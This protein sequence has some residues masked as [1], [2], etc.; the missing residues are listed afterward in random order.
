MSEPLHRQRNLPHVWLAGL[1]KDRRYQPPPRDFS[2][3]RLPSRP[4]DVAG[5]GRR[6]AQALQALEQARRDAVDAAL[7]AA[8]TPDGVYISVSGR[9]GFRPEVKK[10]QAAG[11]LVIAQPTLTAD[12]VATD[13][14][15][16]LAEQL[17]V[18]IPHGNI[19]KVLKK[20]RDYAA[21]PDKPK[22]EALVNRIGAF[23]AATLRSF[24]TDASELFPQRGQ[25]AWWEVWLRTESGVGRKHLIV[26][27]ASE[28]I[29]EFRQLAGALDMRVAAPALAFA[30]RAV[31][32]AQASPEQ[33]EQ[34]LLRCSF[35]AELRAVRP[36]PQPF[37][38]MHRGEQ[39]E[40]GADLAERIEHAGETSP[41]V[42]ILDT[43][44]NRGHPLLAASLAA[45]DANTVKS[46][47]GS[48]DHHGHG[49]AM[50]GMA[51]FGDRLPDLLLSTHPVPLDHCLESVKILP[52][53]GAAPNDPELYGA[54][55][56]DAVAEAEAHAPQRK[57]RVFSMS[58]GQDAADAPG[59]PTSWSSAID[60]LAAG[61][62]IDPSKA[63]LNYDLLAEP[64]PRRLF[65]IAAG[66]VD[67]PDLDHLTLSKRSPI[68]SPAQA[69]N[70]LT[71]GAWTDMST[72]RLQD[73]AVAGAQ[74]VA[75]PGNLSPFGRTSADED[76]K[77][78]P[79]KPEVLMEGGNK[80]VLPGAA[81]G[82]GH[83][84]LMLLT[85]NARIPEALFTLSS[86]TSAATAQAARMA[87]RMQAALPGAW[88]ETI[89]A[90]I[91][92]SARWTPVMEQELRDGRRASVDEFVRTFG[93]G[94]PDLRRALRSARDAL[95]MVSEA[96][97]SPYQ[98]ASYG[99]MHLYELPWPVEELRRLHTEQVRLR[100]TL[101]YFVDPY[102]VRKEGE[103]AARYPSTRLRFDFKQSLE[104]PAAF[105]KRINGRETD[106]ADS[107][108]PREQGSWFLGST[109]RDV[110][111][112]HHDIWTG[113]AAELADKGVLAITPVAGWMRDATRQRQGRDLQ[114]YT[115]VV[116]VETTTVD[117]DL[118]A[119]VTTP[120]P[121]SEL[122]VDAW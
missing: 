18:F 75:L 120:V 65:F 21:N 93:Y 36:H 34:M 37:E 121:V 104:T 107:K 7:G 108:K 12:G 100:V 55:T 86:M 5:H 98:D 50:A 94:V 33:L 62:I 63:A 95:T 119:E 6:L 80:Y 81:A 16:S 88:P 13:S 47:W 118:M 67:S 1:A 76:F 97:L 110:G 73:P 30:D 105:L 24:W 99:N 87:A 23:Q 35:L 74:T 8:Q 79:I 96:T 32:L 14:R 103:H 114:R 115:L 48:A 66:N 113:K 58:I 41:A 92:H 2:G 27:T 72:A 17:T 91:V 68:D 56:R 106:R 11:L 111:S 112:L 64:A 51:L 4:A 25:Q 44:V 101:S 84:D 28:R 49:T 90:L 82:D 71:V 83:D 122:E 26:D 78:W 10:L 20:L 31:V 102:P 9:D 59:E 52:P 29:A 116:S 45:A 57:H 46:A 43:G 22:N 53:R 54:V 39:L 77:S 3:A 85:T 109:K 15:D 42:C 61:R 40:W 89:R 60:A 69:W 38:A 117:A 70:A 19:S